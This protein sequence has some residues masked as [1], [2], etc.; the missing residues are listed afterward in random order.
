[1]A[2]DAPSRRRSPWVWV[3]ALAVCALPVAYLLGQR[4]GPGCGGD[5]ERAARGV[6]AARRVD[7]RRAEAPPFEGHAVDVRFGRVQALA[8]ALPEGVARALP[9]SA[10]GVVEV[11]C[12]G[13]PAAARATVPE[14]AVV[15]AAV[16]TP[17]PG[18]VE[19]RALAVRLRGAARR[20][21]PDAVGAAPGPDLPLADEDEAGR[22]W[23]RA[24]GTAAYLDGDVLVCGVDRAGAEAAGDYVSR[25]ALPAAEREGVDGAV[26]L[27]SRE[28]FAALGETLRAAFDGLARSWRESAEAA[29]AARATPPDLG[30]P[31]R[32]VDALHER[33]LAVASAAGAATGGR[34][35]LRPATGDGGGVALGLDI[36]LPEGGPLAA[37]VATRADAPRRALAD[38][39]PG[40]A[41]VAV[42]P[43]A[44][45]EGA[46]GG[47]ATPAWLGAL[48]GGPTGARSLA[49]DARAAEDE[50]AAGEERAAAAALLRAL[51]ATRVV[52]LGEGLGG[53]YLVAS[54]DAGGPRPETVDRALATRALAAAVAR[55]AGCETE[56]PRARL[57]GPLALDGLALR[58]RELCGAVPQERRTKPVLELALPDGAPTGDAGGPWALAI[59]AAPLGASATPLASAAIEAARARLRA[60]RRDGAVRPPADDEGGRSSAVARLP[61]RAIALLA[62]SPGRLLAWAARFTGRARDGG[63]PGPAIATALPGDALLVALV[64]RAGGLGLEVHATREALEGA[65][66]TYAV[67]ADA[68]D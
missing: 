17:R 13:L 12:P 55:A 15:V 1:M 32:L 63:V 29:V 58:R 8:E 54:G 49:G 51:E 6:G 22:R 39:A 42:L 28:G 25:T 31:V 52:A 33:L 16:G 19:P 21:G 11:A 47:G 23:L 53:A 36:A 37:W 5:G 41:L 24:E 48:L 50:R 34:L 18:G 59:G 56:A 14:D 2:S 46:G 27:A 9:W 57:Q 3:A 7:A 45:H 40:A 30:D 67:V 38:V 60:G 66:A 26:A 68:D 65:L 20:G 64:R 43:H 35:W 4:G 62:V 10:R 44:A 61:E